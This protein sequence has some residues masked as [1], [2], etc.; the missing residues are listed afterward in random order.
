MRPAM[1]IIA[2]TWPGATL[3]ASALSS[4]SSLLFLLLLLLL[5][6]VLLLVDLP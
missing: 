1:A 6:L 5:L 3:M 2:S 4:L